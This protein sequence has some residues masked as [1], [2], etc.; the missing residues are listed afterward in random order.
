MRTRKDFYEKLTEASDKGFYDGRQAKSY[1]PYI[2][3][4]CGN[5]SIGKTF[6][7]KSSY[8]YEY[9]TKGD[10]WVYMRRT[11]TELDTIDKEGF[12]KD[13]T[14]EMIFYEYEIIERKSNR[15]GTTITL[16]GDGV[17]YVI[18]FSGRTVMIDNDV[19]CY[20][21]ALSTWGKVKGAEY[22][23]VRNVLY[24]EVLIDIAINRSY[25][26]HEMSAFLQMV[27]SIERMNKVNYAL[28]SNFTN[29]NNP[30]FN[31]FQFRGDESKRYWYIPNKV[32]K[33]A[34]G[35]LVEFCMDEV[36]TEE[37]DPDYY[38]LAM[39]S[40]VFESNVHGKF[41]E[42]LTGNVGKLTGQ[43]TPLYCLYCG[44]TLLKAFSASPFTG[45][46]CLY[47]A[48]GFDRNLPTYTFD[49]GLLDQGGCHFLA[50]SNPIATA[51]RREFY[52]NNIYYD[53]LDSKNR[54]LNAINKIL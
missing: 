14:F 43:K 30:Y 33:K 48:K 32:N 46:S 13:Q 36:I 38:S 37:S 22:E 8:M 50:R 29:Y 17:T 11:Q 45:A 34:R 39:G 51:I 16:V 44:N 5:R 35:V 54:F 10:Q 25:L 52:S 49:L 20:M 1:N 26:P 27:K 24:D 9:L 21:K 23:R 7:F 31:H 3:F 42:N 2:H 12:I 15:V 6:W 4:C 41:Q 53:D 19:C 18:S 28:L 47:I 40:E